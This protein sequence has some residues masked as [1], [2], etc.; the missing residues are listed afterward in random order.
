MYICCT[1]YR[2]ARCV[3]AIETCASWNMGPW[4]AT[5]H[6]K[7]NRTRSVSRFC[8]VLVYTL[9]NDVSI[10]SRIN[11][12]YIVPATCS[13]FTV[14]RVLRTHALF[15]KREYTE[16]KFSRISDANYV[17]LWLCSEMINRCSIEIGSAYLSIQVRNIFFTSRSRNYVSL[18]KFN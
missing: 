14:K 8:R 5:W 13:F 4:E 10:V 11:I 12:S 7:L 17:S 9:T 6:G 1:R 3:I 2:Y 15:I 16:M 18:F